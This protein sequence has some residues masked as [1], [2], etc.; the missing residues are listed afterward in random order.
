MSFDVYSPKELSNVLTGLALLTPVK[1]TKKHPLWPP[2]IKT[3]RYPTSGIELAAKAH[4]AL[5]R[6][7]AHFNAK[8]LHE[9]EPKTFLW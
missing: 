5:Q 1:K 8:R 7:Y 9:L 6:E 3:D 4:R 2:D